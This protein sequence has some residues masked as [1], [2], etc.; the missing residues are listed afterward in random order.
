MLPRLVY[1][2]F[3]TAMV[4]HIP[5]LFNEM[6]CIKFKKY[7]WCSNASSHGG[8]LF[9]FLLVFLLKGFFTSPI[10]KKIE[11]IKFCYFWN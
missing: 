1:F 10:L 6:K 8:D 2:I 5:T 11:K 9:F 4:K 3:F 7:W